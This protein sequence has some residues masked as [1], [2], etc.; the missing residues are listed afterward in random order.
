MAL[1]GELTTHWTQPGTIIEWAA[2]AIRWVKSIW[3]WGN[4][5]L[6]SQFYGYDCDLSR[7]V[8]DINQELLNKEYLM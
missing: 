5:S 2:Q 7:S 6:M 4:F 3:S 1:R 8:C